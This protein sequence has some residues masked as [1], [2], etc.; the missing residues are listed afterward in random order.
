MTDSRKLRMALL[1]TGDLALAYL[2]LWLTLLSRHD[3][4]DFPAWWAMHA[5][6]FTFAFV[7]WLAVFYVVGLYDDDAVRGR[8]ELASRTAEALA[9]AF[10]LSLAVFY[11]MPG[12]GIAPKTNLLLATALFAGLFYGWR[13]LA[14]H[15]FS[16]R[17][18]HLRVLFLGEDAGLGEVLSQNPHLGYSC[19]GVAD[20][21]SVRELPACDLIVVSRRLQ[22][23][24]AL[25]T[26][27]YRKFF[28]RAAIV[29]LPTFYEKIR[30]AVPESALDERWIVDNLAGQDS[31]M[32]EHAKRLF[33]VVASIL[34]CIPSLPVAPLIAAII[35]IE[36]RG[37]AFYSQT[38]VGKGGRPFTMLK[39][40][41]MRV[42][43]EKD[44]IAFATEN[45]PRVTRFGRFLRATRLD[46]LPQL[47]NILRGDM[48]FVGPRPERPEVEAELAKTIPLFPVRHLVRPGLTGWAQ[49]SAP[50]AATHEDH[51]LKL[52]HDL[53][54]LKYRSLTL[55]AAIVLK[56]IYSVLKRKG[57]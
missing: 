48:S 55:D 8:I 45:D 54:Y 18:F 20:E 38:R 44:G 21:S 52:R 37:P 39:F 33:D 24:A 19:L 5:K 7:I 28:E 46:E 30:H 40:R 32:Y 15:L 53:Y 31:P 12:I 47:W 23:N 50:Y 25:T 51:L 13:I 36:S 17:R 10:L 34:L 22:G 6:P 29:D 26:R 1:A 43:A 11:F 49:V 2:A 14:L 9:A 56:T 57:R 16:R 42:D 4:Q 41:T 27:L 35:R 3:G